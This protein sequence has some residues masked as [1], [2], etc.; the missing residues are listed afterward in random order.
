MWLVG[1]S[2]VLIIGLAIHQTLLRSVGPTSTNYVTNELDV[3]RLTFPTAL[4]IPESKTK[5][6]WSTVFAAGKPIV[7]RSLLSRWAA[8]QKWSPKY[9]STKW[10]PIRVHTADTNTV[11]MFSTV[12][13]F[14]RVPDLTWNASYEETIVPGTVFFNAT[15]QQT[16]QRHPWMYFFSPVEQLPHVLHSDFQ[17]LEQL[18]TSI[19]SAGFWSGAPTVSS[20][21][22]YDAAH[23]VY[24]QIFGHKRFIL[25]PPNASN[26]LYVHSRLHPST[27]SSFIDVRNVDAFRFPLFEHAMKNGSLSPM[28][29]VLGPGDVLY[30]PP[31]YWHRAS[32]V[33]STM[34][35]SLAV[36]STSKMMNKYQLLKS[37]PV[38]IDTNWLW[39]RK[40]ASLK[41][42]ICA[43]ATMWDTPTITA[44]S[45]AVVATTN[46]STHII[47]LLEQRYAPQSNDKKR[48]NIAIGW[49]DWITK[50]QRY[51]QWTS[52]SVVVPV[53]VQQYLKG[54]VIKLKNLLLN[55]NNEVGS[56]KN[57]L[58]GQAMWSLETMNLIEDVVNYVL[59]TNYCEP[60]FRWVVGDL[61]LW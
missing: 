40:V 24:C 43:L 45:T 14:G 42:Y 4:P 60:F 10:T 5:R 54:H 35:M 16:T 51:F 11:R 33:G 34:S 23:N 30:I 31:Y 52:K 57:D 3:N 46:C 28:E 36:Y 53:Q 39:N 44:T 21:L 20:P 6:Q 56:E 49:N 22:H 50:Y 9:L 12:Q 61:V 8:I 59:G 15:P 26:V 1:T 55:D 18:G 32:V 7:F 37:Y 58:I 29:V 2:V 27:R 38:P 19:D 17:R 48:R 47:R 41:T 13:P 25:F